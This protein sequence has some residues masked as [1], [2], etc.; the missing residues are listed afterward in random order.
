MTSSTRPLLSGLA[1]LCLADPASAQVFTNIS[2]S[3][4]PRATDQGGVQSSISTSSPIG[5]RDCDG[6]VW[7]FTVNYS[8]N[9]GGV[10]TT[11]LG[12][13]VGA[14]DTACDSA[15]TRDPVS[16]GTARCWPIRQSPSLTFTNPTTPLSYT[17]RI[18]SRFLVDPEYGNCASPGTTQ[19]TS[20]TNYLAALV[21]P[22][23]ADNVIG[24]Y[25]VAYDVTA[26]DAP[27][28]VSTSTGENVAVVTWEYPGSVSTDDAGTTSG[29]PADL[30]GYYLLCDPAPGTDGDAG[31][32]TDT[33]VL[34]DDDEDD[35]TA[36]GA[37]PLSAL[38]PNDTATFERYRCSD[39]LGASARRGV[40]SNLVNGRQYHLAV[41]AQDLAGNRSTVAV[42]SNCV[43]PAPVTD[44]WELYRANGGQAVP[45]A[46]SVRVGHVGGSY[47][48]PTIA[49]AVALWMR[50]R[51]PRDGAVTDEHCFRLFRAAPRGG[52]AFRSVSCSRPR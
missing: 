11:S 47:A 20:A 43:T 33:A 9:P 15:S 19:G 27:T 48:W 21:F 51:R 37:T 4:S 39:L 18:E 2:R 34:P 10:T 25:A 35:V 38:D 44:F 22:P 42:A 7:N 40:A 8:S 45:G 46:C 16:S 14:D 12:Y 31:T 29:A 6:E 5:L 41:V 28:S 24:T 36:C 32:A 17:I 23:S 13:Y 26:P 30:D 3:G 50:R 52:R 1:V 49:L